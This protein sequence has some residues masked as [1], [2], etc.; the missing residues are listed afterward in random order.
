MDN[1]EVRLC[2][3]KSIEN[4]IC[5]WKHCRSIVCHVFKVIHLDNV[6]YEQFLVKTYEEQ[7]SYFLDSSST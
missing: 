7:V 1:F 5:V 6:N 2:G 4:N 3:T